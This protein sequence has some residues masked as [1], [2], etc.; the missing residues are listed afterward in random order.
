MIK[1]S[2]IMPL[3]NAEK[4][5]DETLQSIG[6]QSFQEYEVICIDDASTDS[7]MDILHR[8]QKID[9]RIRIIN[10]S[11]HS[12]AAFS[13]NKGIL[14]AKGKYIS[15]LDGDDIFDEAMLELSFQEI[16]KHNAD[17]VMFE[18]KHVQSEHIY[19]KKRIWRSGL[20]IERYCKKTFSVQEF[21]PIEFM[22]WTCA[23]WNKLYRKSLLDS[24]QLRF[25]SLTCAND[26]YFVTMAL[27]LSPKIIMLED[28]RVMLYARDHN[29]VTR[30][31][32]DRDPMCTYWAMMKLRNELR[33]RGLFD[34]LFQYYYCLL[35]YNLCYA[36]VRTKRI[37]NAR[38]FYEF[39]QKEGIDNFI[40]E[41]EEYYLKTEE[42]ICKLLENYK[43]LDFETAW[44]R[45]EGKINFYLIK[46]KERVLSFFQSYIR[47]DKQVV[48][49]GAGKN[50]SILLGFLRSHDIQALEVVD[51]D[52]RKQE[53]VISG[54][55]IRKP[56]DCLQNADIVITSS[57]VIYGE[58]AAMLEERG[59]EVIDIGEVL[60][61]P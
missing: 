22:N 5:L 44:Y 37:E 23:P 1:I 8:F 35:L 18:Y 7:T 61:M 12:G 26:V 40:R 27:M 14:E 43:K 16:E 41:T 51:G 49:W 54:Y 29:V 57:Y 4:Y 47:Q 10:N 50:G 45:Y 46:N 9:N 60:G 42:R 39:L 32:Y 30:I 2:I 11:E 56:K 33:E 59:I 15:F 17:I 20:F 38:C 58:V 34:K 28:R 3:Y 13:R 48:I 53:T 21:E 24:N 36:I 6:K 25:Q 31:S 19:E 55:E 52:V